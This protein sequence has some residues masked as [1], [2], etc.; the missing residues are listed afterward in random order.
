MRL[1]TRLA[2]ILVGVVVVL[3]GFAYAVQRLVVYPSFLT[4]E[5]AE[6]TKDLARAEEALASEVEHLTSLS[7]DW[8]AWDDTYRFVEDRNDE[9]RQSNLLPETFGSARVNLIYF[10][11]TS[12]EV[13]WGEIRE[14]GTGTLLSVPEL[15]VASPWPATHPLLK[16]D[17]ASAPI[18][19]ARVSGLMTTD[20]G[21]MLIVSLPILTSANEGPSRGAFLMGRFLTPAMVRLLAEQTRVALEVWPVASAPAPDYEAFRRITGEQPVVLVPAG[22]VLKVYTTVAD[23]TGAPALLLRVTVPRDISK[24]GTATLRY[25][26]FS[27]LAVG[28]VVFLVSRALVGRAVV[29]PIERLTDH[30]TAVGRSQDLSVPM[31]VG[32]SD[33]IGTL[34]GELGSMMAS[35]ADA[36][37]R[38]LEESYR[39][40]VARMAAESLHN[41][42]NALT[43]VSGWVA[44][45]RDEWDTVP[46]GRLQQAAQ[47]LASD[48]ATTGRR[49]DLAHYVQ[50][51]GQELEA[52]VERARSRCDSLLAQTA[53]IEAMLA[54]QDK[55]SHAEPLLE[56]I[57]VEQV[58]CEARDR[59]PAELRHRVEPQLDSSLHDLPRLSSERFTLV[60]VLECLLTNAAEAVCRLGEVGGRIEVS[61]EVEREGE[62]ARVHLRVRDTGAGIDEQALARIFERGYSTKPGGSSGFGVHWSANAV[63]ALG[64][65]MSA[66]SPGPGQGACFNL[67]LP[68]GQAG[69]PDGGET[70]VAAS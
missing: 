16:F 57:E 35:L 51:V 15:P 46:L 6:A 60:R 32:G 50:L 28:L 68:I 20:A 47:E 63:A 8:A 36:R 54:V 31:P 17:T 48:P 33:E 58:V 5:S 64:G 34:A 38:L 25:A 13:V 37:R 11:S 40:G 26:A 19:E 41:V 18:T 7:R 61:G 14:L 66:E 42:R 10:V 45:L 62:N 23:V 4:L 29:A 70:R 1:R 56:P 53:G 30:A 44:S 52:T 3:A 55:H 2:L 49:A 65:Q 21:P 43:P 27:I 9:Y 12:G 59:L 22:K 39:A 67:W 69:R 24:I